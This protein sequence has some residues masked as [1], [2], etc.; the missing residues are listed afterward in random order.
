VKSAVALVP[1]LALAWAAIVVVALALV[2]CEINARIVGQDVPLAVMPAKDARGQVVP[3]AVTNPRVAVAWG[4]EGPTRWEDVALLV[5][6]TGGMRVVG[7]VSASG[8]FEAWADWIPADR[9]EVPREVHVPVRPVAQAGA[10][11]WGGELVGMGVAV[12][13]GLAGLG[14]GAVKARG[15]AMLRRA[16]GATIA[17]GIEAERVEPDR[18]DQKERLIEKHMA[19]QRAAG[20]H[21]VIA[22][23]L[24]K[25]KGRPSSRGV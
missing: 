2:G 22:A 3:L 20:V 5:T 7:V 18:P 23:E 10:G 13:M 9:A 6:A 16:L 24:E 11:G 14:W 17:Y 8:A 1:S 12:A 19:V 21:G 4:P 25:V 15:Q